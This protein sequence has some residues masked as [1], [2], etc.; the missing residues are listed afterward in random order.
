MF[1][2][3]ARLECWGEA[4][5]K[6]QYQIDQ[7]MHLKKACALPGQSPRLFCILLDFQQ[8]QK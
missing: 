4:A 3:V 1:S 7:L 5:L 8:V 6:I 2:K